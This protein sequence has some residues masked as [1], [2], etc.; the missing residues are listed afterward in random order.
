VT[1]TSSK[2]KRKHPRIPYSG[3]VDLKFNDHLFPGCRAQ[4]LSLVGIWLMGCQDQEEGRLCDIEFHDAAPTANR[5]LRL[6]GEVVR[7]E[8]DGIALLFVD[9][10]LRAYG[11]LEA[12][13]NEKGGD[14]SFTTEDF[15]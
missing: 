10:N 6:K 14:L 4:N 1:R 11:D 9:M 3:K 5:P 2:L 7:V 15:L 8:N 12:L 13:I